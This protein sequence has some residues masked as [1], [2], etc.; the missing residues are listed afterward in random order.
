MTENLLLNWEDKINS[1][2]L[3][4]FLSQFGAQYY[5][6]AGEINA[7]RD[8]I[9]Y[10]NN[11]PPGLSDGLVSLGEIIRDG[12]DF[13]FNIDVAKWRYSGVLISNIN[14]FQTTIEP[15]NDGF[16]RRDFVG[17][18]QYG[19][20]LLF[21]GEENDEVA[22]L[23]DL[24]AD[25]TLIKEY[26]VFGAIV[27]DVPPIQ[28]D[29]YYQR[30]YLGD[31]IIN[32]T[33]NNVWLPNISKGNFVVQNIGNNTILGLS[34]FFLDTVDGNWMTV[35]QEFKIT[36]KSGQTLTLKDKF[37]QF[38]VFPFNFNNNQDFLAEDN[39][40]TVTRFTGSELMFE[41]YSKIIDV[42]P[43]TYIDSQ[44]QAIL[45]TAKS[46]SD[47]QDVAVLNTAKSYSDS[48]DTATLNAAKS[49]AEGLVTG[50]VDLRGNYNP[51]VNSNLYPTTGGSGNSGAVKKG[52]VW[53]ISG[54]GV[55]AFAII[56][57]KLVSDGDEIMSLVDAPVNSDSNWNI[58][59][60]NFTY[61][62]EN[63]AN[64]THD[65]TMSTSSILF[66]TEGK[67]KAYFDSISKKRSFCLYGPDFSAAGNASAHF[68]A[69]FGTSY[70]FITTMS[71]SDHNALSG[72]NAYNTQVITPYKCKITNIQM[73]LNSG[74][75]IANTEISIWG[76]ALNAVPSSNAIEYLYASKPGTQVLT[77]ADVISNTVIPANTPLR[78]YIKT[79]SSGS[80]SVGFLNIFFEEE[81]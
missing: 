73:D 39:T 65:G 8:K 7:I 41:S 11:K 6:S 22:F 79:G 44:D 35:G 52:D 21:V 19:N 50:L 60:H 66:P 10:L 14:Q 37:E 27:D 25:W 53:I 55:G 75:Y 42:T 34:A 49:Y 70:A 15:A 74:S 20:L 40:I 81:Y 36:N 32:S 18:D 5:L 16:Y 54:L 64:K 45:N 30:S 58:T 43:K 29:I 63:T 68:M 26:S 61:V 1:P 67:V 46:Y 71:T 80:T 28:G 69:K 24:P 4:A 38:G 78:I 48:Q 23:P 77:F 72:L 62:P 56:G 33:R 31:V 59:E 57:T 76:R 51:A 12:N 9:N 13:T 17:G 47:T 2:D 3:E